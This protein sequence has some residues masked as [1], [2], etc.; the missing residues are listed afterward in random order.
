MSLLSTGRA[1]IHL[2]FFLTPSTTVRSR[3]PQWSQHPGRRPRLI[4]LPLVAG[5]LI[6]LALTG[7]QQA[8]HAQPS[9]PSSLHPSADE[10]ALRWRV[11][12][13]LIDDGSR[14]R[15]TLTL[16]NN[17]DTA[18]EGTGWTLYF[19]FMRDIDPTT[20]TAPVD[21]TRINGDFYR[22][23]PTDAFT[24][25]APDEQLRI[26]FD[27]IGSAIK[28]IDAP[29]GF[30][31]VFSDGDGKTDPPAPIP[32]MSVAPF[33]RPVQKTRGPNDVWPVPTAASRYK[34]NQ[35]LQKRPADSV[36]R[37]VPTPSMVERGDGS[38][39]LNADAT[40]G[41]E[42]GLS[43]EAQQLAA[44]LAP[45]LGG[46]PTTTAGGE[47]ASIVLR[48]AKV[49]PPRS[50]SA[51]PDA[52]LLT[53]DPENGIEIVGSTK[54][55]VF[56]GIQS[57]EAW[58]PVSAYRAPSPPVTVPAARIVD[59]PRF[60]Y[61]GL[62]LDVS[63]NF[64]SMESV[65]RLLD[66]MA[67]YKLDTF[68][69]H[70][71]DDEGW[72]LAIPGLPEL[73]EVGGRR[74]HTLQENE[75]LVPSHGSGPDPSPSASSGSGWYSRDQ[76]LEILRYAKARHINV[77]P[78]IDVPGHARAALQAMKARW[79][80]LRAAGDTAAAR[81]YRIHDPHDTS[82]YESVQGWDDNVMNVCQSSTYRFLTKVVD[83]LRALHETAGAP[84]HSVHVGGD[85]VPDGVWTES[86]VCDEYIA[87][88]ETVD[89]PD[90]LFH[91]FLVR[92]RDTLATRDLTLAGWEEVGLE[93]AS[94]QARTSTPNQD[95]A[96]KG[97]RPYVWSN[98]WGGGTEDRAYRL[99][100]A[101]YEIVM[102]Q[103]T[104]FYFDMAYS[105]HPKED[106]LYWT[107][108]VDTKAP[109]SFVPFDLYK[110]AHRTSMGQ[111]I[112]PSTFFSGRMPL[113]D[114]AKSNIR[115]L[116]GQLWGETLRTSRRME[117]MAVPRLLSLAE[118]AWAQQ[119]NWA[120][121]ENI[122][123]LRTERDSAWAAFANRLGQR[124]LPR[125]SIRAPEWAYRLPPPGAVIENG[126]LKANVGLPGL[127]VRYTTDG[128]K[129]TSASP[130]YTS[131]VSVESDATVK[132]RTFDTLGRGGRT[133]TV[134][135]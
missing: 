112:D 79:T 6:G 46:R 104:N 72:R 52:Y 29:S 102:S 88:T 3:S 126:R 56:Y 23:S 95:L 61:R 133:V 33:T 117:Y 51:H 45:V 84:L 82:T 18:L 21:V 47:E 10:L 108:F 105:K 8:I 107:G 35:S 93:E 111:E 26:R 30:Y 130:Q 135:P 4:V 9:E 5:V 78:E 67:S 42:K 100:N 71:T 98:V 76:Y 75:H 49:V 134:R 118:R 86:P 115:G 123:R 120:T 96:D 109:F 13:N 24:P 113:A 58:L 31:V 2:T 41:Y 32:N 121:M 28:W 34:E 20:V 85:E 124:E 103:A 122:D 19:N 66:I 27:A 68:H 15:S 43:T 38:F 106:G 48:M 89:E 101:G 17:G 59:G 14:F 92:L 119:P 63:R 57:L 94:H 60:D 110:S 125:L 36:G 37:I 25:I 16:R 7:G 74:G 91:H 44:G 50:D 40:I 69:F 12:T 131:P 1:F 65:K 62:H 132:L 11:E 55:G 128:S 83:E 77:M 54:T 87:Q 81:R 127:P 114:S 99:A 97:V 64:Q 73:T 129:P 53:I 116:Q 80:R 90:D 22:L 70:L 39:R